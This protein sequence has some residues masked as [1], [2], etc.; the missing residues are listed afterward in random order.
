MPSAGGHVPRQTDAPASASAFAM[1]KPKP[2]SSATPA[3]NAR[4]PE[5]SMPSMAHVCRAPPRAS[6][7][8]A[9]PAALFVAQAVDRPQGRGLGRREKG[10]QR[11]D[12]HRDRPDERDLDGPDLDGQPIDQINL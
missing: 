2:P 5:R 10:R 3:T 7:R 1:A 8:T 11:A 4:L 9:G 6:T 12:E